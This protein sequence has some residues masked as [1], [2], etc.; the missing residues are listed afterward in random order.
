MCRGFMT[1]STILFAVTIPVRGQIADL[2]DPKRAMVF[3]LSATALSNRAFLFRLEAGRAQG[4]GHVAATD[5]ILP[6]RVVW[7]SSAGPA[8][9]ADATRQANRETGQSRGG[10]CQA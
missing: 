1:R 2:V 7:Y 6:A 4:D 10:A 8:A 5:A 9:T 3:S